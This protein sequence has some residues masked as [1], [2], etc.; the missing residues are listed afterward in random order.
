MFVG[1]DG[2][3]Y[4]GVLPTDGDYTV[5]VYLMRPAARRNESSNYTLTIGVT[6]KALAPLSAS[7]MRC[8]RHAVPRI[9][10]DDVHAA[11]RAEAATVRGV[12]H[13]AW[14]RRHRHGRSRAPGAPTRRILFVAGVPVASDATDSDRALARR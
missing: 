1:Q 14:P 12:R 2:D 10:A 4:K 7:R 11:V 5:R 6:G 8:P 13:P 3:G 9:G